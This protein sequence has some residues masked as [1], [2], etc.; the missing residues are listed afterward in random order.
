VTSA[1]GGHCGCLYASIG[2]HCCSTKQLDHIASCQYRCT[3]VHASLRP[4]PGYFRDTKVG[5]GAKHEVG[6]ARDADC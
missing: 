3:G 1:F 5:H 4:S 6:K 2:F